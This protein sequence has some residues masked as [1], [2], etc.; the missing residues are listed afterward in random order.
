MRSETAMTFAAL[1][2]LPP[3]WIAPLQ[4]PIEQEAYLKTEQPDE[5]DWSGW[6]VAASGDTV[7]VGTWREASAATGI[8]GDASDDTAPDAG[9]VWVF[10]RTAGSWSQQAYLK[11]SNAEG[12]DY[13]G[14]SVAIC[15]DTIVV[16]APYEGSA[17]AGVGGDQTSNALPRSGAAY[18]FVRSGA[19][20]SQEAYLKA[21]NPDAP[22]E[23]GQSVAISNDTI[24]VGARNEASSAT[25]VNGDENDDSSLGAGAAYVFV[26]SGTV[27]SQQAYLKASNADVGDRFG[28]AVDVSE[29]TVVVGAIN[30]ASSATGVDGAEADNS[31]QFAGAAYVFARSGTSWNQTAYLKASNTDGAPPLGLFGDSFGID[32]AVS[33]ARVVVGA[34]N[35]DSTS[36]GVDGPDNNDSVD[37]GAAY[38]FVR[39]PSGWV[40]EAYLKASNTGAFDTFGCGVDIAGDTIVVGAPGEGSA[41][42]GV[43]GDQDDDSLYGAGAAYVF[44]RSA[45]GWA[46]AAYIKASNPDGSDQFGFDLSIASGLVALGAYAEDGG[47]TGVNGDEQDDS[48]NNAGATYAFDISC[49][50]G[51]SY[52]G[53]AVANSTGLA[54]FAS[55]CGSPVSANADFSLTAEALPPNRFGYFLVSDVQGFTTN[56]G[57]SQGHLCLGQP[58]GRFALQ[59]QSSGAAGVISIPVDLGAVPLFGA[60]S[61]GDTL[62]FQAWY[63]D[64]NPASTS[65]FSDAVAVTF[66]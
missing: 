63:R 35:E 20:W 61:V 47:A 2:L 51:V 45:A 21:S 31:A 9:A 8:D 62:Y 40:Q 41:A 37:S 15:G 38:V 29:D 14:W 5:H 43:D 46:Q 54:A 1:C 4:A 65:N 50:I 30:E 25:G 22:D 23:F 52:C 17:A 3:L 53:P 26:R 55:A 24:I 44:D 12:G 42:T 19:T 56:P 28:S 10:V 18:V 48:L 13:F 66:E 34:M 49:R 6:S 60:V 11:G 32:V 7:V 39:E 16:G 57:G 64:M 59:V 36:T 27:W 58:I 33:G